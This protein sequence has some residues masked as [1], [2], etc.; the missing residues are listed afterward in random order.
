MF[1]VEWYIIMDAVVVGSKID[2]SLFLGWRDSPCS[3]CT[4][5][6]LQLSLLVAV[7]M[8]AVQLA[9]GQV[10]VGLPAGKTLS[11]LFH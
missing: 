3:S 5:G 7:W 4:F 6:L 9:V 8:L 1:E 11:L 2:T 10:A